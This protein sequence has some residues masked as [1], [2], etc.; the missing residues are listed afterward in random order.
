VQWR[1]Y[2]FFE[3]CSLFIRHLA[4]CSY[5]IFSSHGEKDQLLRPL[6]NLLWNTTHS[7]A[8]VH[9]S[10]CESNGS[11]G[12]Y[13]VPKLDVLRPSRR[14]PG[15]QLPVVKPCV[16]T[17]LY[18]YTIW[19]DTSEASVSTR[20]SMCPKAN[21]GRGLSKF[22]SNISASDQVTFITSKARTYQ[23]NE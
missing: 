2:C 3:L 22:I 17:C 11:I 18:R 23:R 16:M 6:H 5:Q 20:T 21:A 9:I 1:T 10:T 19:S 4:A 12:N 15:S 8:A 7:C 14:L 13:H